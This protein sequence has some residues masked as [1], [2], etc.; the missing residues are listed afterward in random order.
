M[1]SDTQINI[2]LEVQLSKK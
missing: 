2:T 1:I